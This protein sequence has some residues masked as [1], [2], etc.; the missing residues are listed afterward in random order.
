MLFR[1]PL[2]HR[3]ST[4]QRKIFGIPQVFYKSLGKDA[5]CIELMPYHHL[6]DSKYQALDQTYEMADLKPPSPDLVETVKKTFEANGVQCL[7]S[8]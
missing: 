7:V 2:I 3:E 5:C 8:M 4:I 1:M 6:A